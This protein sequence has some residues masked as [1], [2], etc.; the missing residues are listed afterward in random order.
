MGKLVDNIIAFKLLKML[1]TPFDKTDAYKLGI[2]DDEG[3]LLKKPSKFTKSAEHDAYNYLTRFMF[4][5]KRLVNKFGGENRLKSVATALY[6]FKEHHDALNDSML[7]EEFEELLEDHFCI[8]LEDEYIEL[9]IDLVEKFLAEEMT[10]VDALPKGEAGETTP[11][12]KKKK[13]KIL[14]RDMKNQLGDNS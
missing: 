9:E 7:T 11:I 5:M 4:N 13:Y 10:T 2:I 6:L 3:K 14:R 8:I 1:V 12:V